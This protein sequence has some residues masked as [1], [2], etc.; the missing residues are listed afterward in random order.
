MTK[1]VFY[2]DPGHGYLRVSLKILERLGIMNQISPFSFKSN[3][4]A[5]LEEDMDMTTFVQAYKA[6]GQDAE[7]V[8]KNLDH[9]AGCRRYERFPE[10]EEYITYRKEK[11]GF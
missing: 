5:F 4:Y 9:E 2:A 8:V 7:F 10:T 11:W 3:Y 1:F 6:D